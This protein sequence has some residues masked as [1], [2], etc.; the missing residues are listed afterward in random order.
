MKDS[1]IHRWMHE[2]SADTGFTDS[3]RYTCIYLMR[4]R[5]HS[6]TDN[7]ALNIEVLISCNI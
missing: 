2:N 5:L 3:R 7:S 6:G 4:R 1:W